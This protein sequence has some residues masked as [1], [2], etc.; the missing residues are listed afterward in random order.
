MTR[1]SVKRGVDKGCGQPRWPSIKVVAAG[2]V[3]GRMVVEKTV[4]EEVL[5]IMSFRSCFERWS[6]PRSSRRG[7]GS[8]CSKWPCG[9]RRT[10]TFCYGGNR[11]GSSNHSWCG[12]YRW[13]RA[14]HARTYYG[15]TGCHR[16]SCSSWSRWKRKKS[17]CAKW[18]GSTRY[19]GHLHT[20]AGRHSC[21]WCRCGTSHGNRWRSFRCLRPRRGRN[22]AWQLRGCAAGVRSSTSRRRRAFHRRRGL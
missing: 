9:S 12:H 6:L 7:S 4:V 1:S 20:F 21:S 17:W 19:S 15:K 2:M 3:L 10:W 22:G 14:L 16:S 5:S 8:G 18:N 13:C 11:H